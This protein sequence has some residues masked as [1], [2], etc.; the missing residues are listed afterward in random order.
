MNYIHQINGFWNSP[1]SNEL[2]GNDIA[3]YM[4]ILNYSNS[5]GWMNPFIC[6]WEIIVQYARVSKNTF[7]NSIN[8]LNELDFIDY[9]KGQKNKLSAKIFILNIENKTGIN[10]E[11]NGNNTGIKEEQNGNINKLLNYKTIKLINNN[12]DLVNEHLEKWIKNESSPQMFVVDFDL[13]L[14]EINSRL[15]KKFRSIP[16]KVKKA[17]V[18][19]FKNGYTMD[20]IISA[21]ENIKRTDVHIQSNFKWITPEFLSRE[22]KLM[23]YSSSESQQPKQQETFMTTEDRAKE[24]LIKKMGNSE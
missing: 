16:D 7:Y 19:R 11:Q 8:K 20:D 6:H 10:M 14:N 22:D 4:A 18:A 1:H 24:F 5:L 3:V 23:L 21:I 2:T 17:F 13:L 12:V 9:T 15:N